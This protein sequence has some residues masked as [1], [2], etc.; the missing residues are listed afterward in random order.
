MDFEGDIESTFNLDFTITTQVAPG[1]V[2]TRNLKPDGDSIPVTNHNRLAYVHL[3][4][5]YRLVQEPKLQTA[6]FLKGLTKI[7]NPNWLKMFNQGELQTLV[8]GDTGSPINVEDLRKHT[9]YGGVYLI[10][11]DGQ[12]HETIKLFWQVM[13]ELD[14][15]ERGKVLR[16][17]T[18]VSRAPLL[19]FRVLRP[20]FCIRDAGEDQSR[21]CSASTC[22]NLLKMPRYRNSRI[23]KEK[24]L[25]SVNS[26]AGFDL[27]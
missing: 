8:G 1:K 16:F 9:I 3:V 21:L 14:D 23:L 20:R 11:D 7:I 27:S 4:S 19:G 25:Y 15:A 24:L 10:G 26:N 17:V 12:E 18:S 13:R 6:A 5:K 2:E 22:V